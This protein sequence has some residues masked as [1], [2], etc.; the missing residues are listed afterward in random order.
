LIDADLHRACLKE[1]NLAGANLRRANLRET[2]LQGANLRGAILAK[3][4]LR[5]ANL[6]QADVRQ[7]DLR[8]ASLT[9]A[10]LDGADLK[11][12]LLHEEGFRYVSAPDDRARAAISAEP[13]A[14]TARVSTASAAIAATAVAEPPPAGGKSL[15]FKFGLAGGGLLLALGAV[16][17]LVSRS[18]RPADDRVSQAVSKAVAASSGLDSVKV[19]GE[20][21]IL[22]SGRAKV[23]SGMYLGLLKT[24]CGALQEMEPASGLREIRITNSSGE[25]GWIYRAPEK[26]GEILSK[27]AG[28]TALSIAA[29]TQ[30]I[31]KR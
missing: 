4:D 17:L 19:E 24:A 10:A 15:T 18:P 16:G 30:P 12:A 1:A 6:K 5:D 13:P 29:N 31:R 26:C 7:A 14:R 28:L 11:G 20:A 9:G 27:P 8:E 23:E 22:R 3:T 2:D 25:E 21:L